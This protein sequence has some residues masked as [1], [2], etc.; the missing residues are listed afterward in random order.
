MMTLITDPKRGAGR[1]R[2]FD[3]EGALA[4]AMDLFWR[5]G[6]EGTTTAQLSEAMGIGQTSLYSAYG[7]KE[8]LYREA[9]TLYL[10]RHGQFMVAP[11][12][13]NGS[14]RDAIEQML[15]AAA[16]QFSSASHPLGCMVSCG[17]LQ[18]SAH[19]AALADEMA[20]YRKAAQ[21]A[22]F[23]RLELARPSGELPAAADSRTLAAF[24]AMVVQGLALQ[25]RDGSTLDLLQQLVQQAMLSWPG[26]ETR[27][28]G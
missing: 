18:A 28:R 12:S 5:Q 6:F 25:A 26:D 17:A 7:S 16:T 22:I 21:T 1:P 13:R 2:A 11:F 15:L 27:G 3:R 10:S 9:V 4:I 24:Y 14:A 20:A 8:A 19:S 23:S